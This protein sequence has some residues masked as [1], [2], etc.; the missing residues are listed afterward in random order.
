MIKSIFIFDLDETLCDL[1]KPI[2]DSTIA[3]LKEIENRGNLVVLCSGKPCY[4]LCG[5]LRQVGLSNPVMIGE[6]GSSLQVG[7]DL[8]PSVCCRNTPNAD[9]SKV[10]AH[11]R[12]EIE[13]ALPHLFFQPNDVVL[14]PFFA[15]EEE[16]QVIRSIIDSCPYDMG[17]VDVYENIDCFDIVPHGIDKGQGVLKL[18]E[19]LGEDIGKVVA[20]GNA[21]ND[22]PMFAMVEN[23]IGINLSDQNKA[24]Y[25]FTDIDSA[26]AF[27]MDEFCK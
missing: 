27:A 26:I 3:S 13:R 5:L 2:A 4:Y 10:I 15:K 24:K 11:L 20:F 9:S 23:S 1:G 12:G 22:Y 19:I 14:T 17:A 18:C 6:N 16:R 8:P 7:I 21:S 25:N